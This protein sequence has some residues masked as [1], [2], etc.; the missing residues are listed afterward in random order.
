[1]HYIQDA[2]FRRALHTWYRVQE[3]AM[4]RI[5]TPEYAVH[6][7]QDSGLRYVNAAALRIVLCTGGSSHDCV[8]Y[9]G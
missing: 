5:Q 9:R 3:H 2:E 4:Y 6:R 7:V 1:M 8:M